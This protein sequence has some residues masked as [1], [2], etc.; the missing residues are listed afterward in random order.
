MLYITILE[1]RL[2]FSYKTKGQDKMSITV[3]ENKHIEITKEKNRINC[4][5]FIGKNPIK[6]I[7][8]K[9]INKLTDFIVNNLR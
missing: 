3:N 5:V 1:A 4:Y 8:T 6:G 9:D 7:S 2:T